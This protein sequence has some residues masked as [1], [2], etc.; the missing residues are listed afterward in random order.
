MPIDGVYWSSEIT[1]KLFL[2]RWDAKIFVTVVK[3]VD[4]EIKNHGYAFTQEAAEKKRD[5]WLWS[6]G[7]TP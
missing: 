2:W 4:V 7:E 3:D 6:Q 5:A 1:H